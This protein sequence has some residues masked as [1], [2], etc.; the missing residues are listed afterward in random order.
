[1]C[2]IDEKTIESFKT[3]N[4]SVSE[5]SN[6]LV[7]LTE[8]KSNINSSSNNFDHQVAEH[9]VINKSWN[10]AFKKVKGYK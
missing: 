7:N 1:M 3:S 4:L 10:K 2:D 8:T 9:V 5:I 6:I